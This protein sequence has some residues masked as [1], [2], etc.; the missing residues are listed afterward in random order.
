MIPIWIVIAIGL[1]FSWFAVN[2][3][4]QDKIRP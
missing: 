2:S 1:A 3:R 4:Y